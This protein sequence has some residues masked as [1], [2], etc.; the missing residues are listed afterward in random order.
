MDVA[1]LGRLP[2]DDV[3]DAVLAHELVAIGA[4]D[5]A[6]G[7]CG[8]AEP[9][10][11]AD[12]E[13]AHLKFILGVACVCLGTLQTEQVKPRGDDGLDKQH[14]VA[15]C[16]HTTK[17]GPAVSYF[18]LR[19]DLPHRSWQI[20]WAD[21]K[22]KTLKYSV[23][24]DYP[25]VKQCD[26]MNFRMLVPNAGTRVMKVSMYREPL[27]QGVQD[28]YRMWESVFRNRDAVRSADAECNYC[29]TMASHVGNELSTCALCG[30][31]LHAQCAAAA[32]R[33]LCWWRSSVSTLVERSSYNLVFDAR[34]S[35]KIQEP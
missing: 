23:F 7:Q 13:L 2:E 28:L 24:S 35:E 12:D 15:I 4:A 9:A 16:S 14:N 11:P 30:L 10:V 22:L 1:A 19:H 3:T 32:P 8:V 17:D 29:G 31:S 34:R 25:Y 21:Q 26:I 33:T 20:I 6:A 18:Q 27:S 5:L